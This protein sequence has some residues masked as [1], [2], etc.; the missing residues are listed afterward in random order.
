V[1]LKAHARAAGSAQD[2]VNLKM[3]MATDRPM[4]RIMPSGNKIEIPVQ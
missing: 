4:P 2:R 3:I 1:H